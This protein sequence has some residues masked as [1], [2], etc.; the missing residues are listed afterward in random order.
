MDVAHVAAMAMVH[1]M[2]P[3]KNVSSTKQRTALARSRHP[4]K[5]AQSTQ[6]FGFV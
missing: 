3:P 2:V 5:P 1:R 4:Q 6:R